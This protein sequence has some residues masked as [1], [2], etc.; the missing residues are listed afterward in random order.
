MQELLFKGHGK[1]ERFSIWKPVVVVVI[2]IMMI[3]IIIIIMRSP[4]KARAK[5]ILML[6][7]GGLTLMTYQ[8]FKGYLMTWGK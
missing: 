3:I 8:I 4:T 2:I 7:M 1:N 5:N 6:V